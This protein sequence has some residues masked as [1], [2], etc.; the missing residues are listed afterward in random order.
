[1]LRCYANEYIDMLIRAPFCYQSLEKNPTEVH[2][3]LCLF[4]S[5]FFLW[6]LSLSIDPK[7]HRTRHKLVWT[8]MKK[9]TIAQFS[10][11]VWRTEVTKWGRQRFLGQ[12]K[13]G[14]LYSHW[15][16]PDTQVRSEP[17]QSKGT[18]YYYWWIMCTVATGQAVLKCSLCYWRYS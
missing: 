18:K 2:V 5:F 17:D 11:L 16:S 10:I 4:F 7:I 1:M 9:I 12:C 13:E 15:R 6:S 14:K 3:A 8:N